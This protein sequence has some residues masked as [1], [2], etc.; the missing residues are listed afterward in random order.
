MKS[1][2]LVAVIAMLLAFA[3]GVA[4]A[5]DSDPPTSL[6]HLD[7]TLTDQSGRAHGVDVHRGHPV[8]VTLFYGGC[9]ATCPLIIET[10]R[11]VERQVPA[12]QRAKLRV[13][14]VSIDPEHDT[15]EALRALAAER[16]IDTSRW[17]LARA[18]ASDVRQL[19]ALLD[20]QYRALPSGGFYHSTMISVLTPQGEIAASSSKLGRA[21]PRLVEAAKKGTDLF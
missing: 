1:R 20:V 2:L 17:T 13:L 19:A 8:L 14:L 7:A 3:A 12:A 5:R 6:Y 9:Q 16:R 4:A 18:D 21:D 15:P 11:D 10:L